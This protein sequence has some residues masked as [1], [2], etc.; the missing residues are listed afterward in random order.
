M[1]RRILCE[2]T[3]LGGIGTSRWAHDIAAKRCRDGDLQAVGRLFRGELQDLSA[4]LG[5]QTVLNGT[6]Q[7]GRILCQLPPAADIP[8]ECAPDGGQFQAA[9]LTGCWAWR[10]SYCAGSDSLARENADTV[11]LAHISLLVD[12][13]P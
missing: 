5:A 4:G 12:E 3:P 8:L 11:A 7:P 9:F 13:S 10:S 2:P 6:L 1:P